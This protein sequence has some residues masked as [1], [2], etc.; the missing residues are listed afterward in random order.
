MNVA[1]VIDTLVGGGA[2]GVVRRLALGLARRGQRVFVYCLKAAGAPAERLRAAGVVI[3]EAKSRGLDP[4]LYWRLGRWLRGD[5][6]DVLH[7]HSCAGLVCAF[8]ATR[9]LRIPVMHVRHGWPLGRRSRYARLADWLSHVIECVAVNC[10]T[11]RDRL[12]SGR[13]ARNALHLPNG[14]NATPTVA[15][16]S[17][18]LL[19][20]LCGRSLRGPVVLCVANIR[21]EKDI[22]G[23]VRAFGLLRRESPD[24]ELVCVGSVLDRH[25][26]TDVRRDVREL[27]LEDC[28]H[29]PGHFADAARL[30]PG[31]DVL[32]LG[33]RTEGRPNVILEAMAQRVPIVAAAVGDVGTLD[34]RLA[35]EH[36]LLQHNETALLVPPGNPDALSEALRCALHDEGASRTRARRAAEKHARDCTTGRMVE[37]YERAYAECV[38]RKGRMLG[39]M[40]NHAARRHGPGVVMRHRSAGWLRRSDY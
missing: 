40:R 35:S 5:R 12:P 26:W 1:I 9:L 36:L 2:E 38:R 7:A 23:L 4:L 37:R 19:A 27:R 28:V 22:R 30:M 16:Q 32:C 21:P 6:I 14:V 20:E 29:F 17:R 15:G 13:V 10:Q 39:R 25:Y 11:G 3:R 33:S 18:E 24:A 34:P 31:A 8:P